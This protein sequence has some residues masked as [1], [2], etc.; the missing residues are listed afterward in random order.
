MGVSFSARALTCGTLLPRAPQ[1]SVWSKVALENMA[2]AEQAA[3]GYVE[4]PIGAGDG[5]GAVRGEAVAEE[6]I[7]GNARY[8]EGARG[9]PLT[10]ATRAIGPL[11]K[12]AAV[13]LCLT[14]LPQ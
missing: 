11:A 5:I 2:A 10:A 12:P 13:V 7:A 14:P 1:F 4:P 8:L 6:L 9:L 3:A